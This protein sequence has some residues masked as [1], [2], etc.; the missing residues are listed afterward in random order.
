M[1]DNVQF[2]SPAATVFSLENILLLKG[3][4]VVAGS[5]FHPRYPA[6]QLLNPDRSERWRAV[7][8]ASGYY[9][10]AFDLAAVEAGYF[11]IFDTVAFIDCR[12]VSAAGVESSPVNAT[13]VGMNALDWAT[14]RIDYIV[15]AIDKD[16]GSVIVSHLQ[17]R[18]APSGGGVVQGMPLKRFWA[19]VFY[20]ANAGD[21]VELGVLWLGM[22]RE[23]VV[24]ARWRTMTESVSDTVQLDSGERAWVRHRRIRKLQFTSSRVAARNATDQVVTLDSLDDM[25]QFRSAIEQTDGRPIIVDPYAFVPAIGSVA[26]DYKTPGAIYGYLGDRATFDHRTTLTGRYGFSIDEAV[27]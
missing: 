11:P 1:A 24:E 10:V 6:T 23:Q 25:E 16:R 18:T 9:Y 2:Y 22:R 14:D 26:L 21:W 17:N 20:L 3:M 15:P 4:A 19:V 12:H 8:T 7:A 5:N 27:P 13:I